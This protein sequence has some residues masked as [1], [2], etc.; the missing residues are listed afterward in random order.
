MGMRDWKRIAEAYGR[1]LTARELD[2]IAPPLA[3]LEETFR[4]LIQG[5]TP[6]LEPDVELHL[7]PDVEPGGKL[8]VEPGGKLDVEP[9]EKLDVELQGT[10][11][12]A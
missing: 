6:D 7:E 1:P 5:L 4:P 2:R 12:G 10:E 8:D 3:A 11:A 9:V